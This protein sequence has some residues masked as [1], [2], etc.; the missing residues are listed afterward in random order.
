MSES[1][2]IKENQEKQAP[3]ELKTMEKIEESVDTKVS[4]KTVSGD[5]KKPT[6]QI[7]EGGLADQEAQ[8][9]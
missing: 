9:Y 4:P 5:E 1:K 8:E 6:P 3:Q 7:A 2:E